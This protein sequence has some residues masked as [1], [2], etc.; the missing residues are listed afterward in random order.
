M[1][2]SWWQTV[3]AWWNALPHWVVVVLL[4]VGG[5]A[6]NYVDSI[7]PAQLLAALST[8]AGALALLKGAAVAG[9]GGLMLLVKQSF[10]SV[11]S[12]A[13]IRM[14]KKAAAMRG[15]VRGE[16]LL[17]VLLGATPP[18]AILAVAALADCTPAA[19]AQ[20]FDVSAVVLRDILAGADL[21][22][23]EADVTRELQKL[24]ASVVE[25]DVALVVED[26]INLLLDAKAIPPSLVPQ[27]KMRAS[28]AHATRKGQTQP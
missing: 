7:P 14:R 5:A 26:A 10:V 1:T 24:D 2:P 4:T 9:L 17:A 21:P 19:R 6:Y 18:L 22:T 3:L 25:I 28:E 20:A 11:P 8:S 15:F 12:L 13:E 16:I 23:I 27:A